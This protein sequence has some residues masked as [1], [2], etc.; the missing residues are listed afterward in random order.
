MWR[1]VNVVSNWH[2]YWNN[3]VYSS[4]FKLAFRQ[5]AIVWVMS[6][7]LI[8]WDAHRRIDDEYRNSLLSWQRHSQNK[9]FFWPFFL[10]LPFD[11]FRFSIYGCGHGRYMCI[12]ESDFAL[13]VSAEGKM[14]NIGASS[15]EGILWRSTQQYVYG[16]RYTP[17]PGLPF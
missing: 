7:P 12:C 11:A 5:N 14:H 6:S 8:I 13:F 17:G 10:Q 4:S 3:H 16:I 1:A 9:R 2:E 15:I